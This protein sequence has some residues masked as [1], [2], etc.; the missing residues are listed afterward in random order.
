MVTNTLA[1][2]SAHQHSAEC[3]SFL[4]GHRLHWTQ[5]KHASAAQPLEVLRVVPHGKVFEVVIPGQSSLLWR[6]HDPDQ[7]RA[8]LEVARLPIIASPQWR[9][10][11]VDGVWFNCVPAE[12]ELTLC[13]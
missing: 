7:L 6:H 4:P 12:A 10:L 8:A 5:W 9:M 13:G 2:T 3:S 11:R 1:S